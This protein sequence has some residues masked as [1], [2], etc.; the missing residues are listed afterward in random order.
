MS[1]KYETWLCYVSFGHTY[2]NVKFA[3]HTSM[4]GV[5]FQIVP[6]KIINSFSKAVFSSI[7]LKWNT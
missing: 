5:K 3:Y 2:D 1:Y 6:Y 4:T 7:S